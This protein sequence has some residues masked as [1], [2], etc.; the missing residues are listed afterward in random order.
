MTRRTRRAAA[1]R[2]RADAERQRSERDRQTVRYY[3]HVRMEWG[4]DRP[5]NLIR[6]RGDGFEEV[7]EAGSGWRPMGNA[8]QKAHRWSPG[9]VCAS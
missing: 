5:L 8:L 2:E 3:V 9:T 7:V 1:A 4:M 6:V